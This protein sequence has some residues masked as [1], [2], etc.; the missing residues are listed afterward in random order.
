MICMATTI[1]NGSCT[2]NQKLIINNHKTIEKWHTEEEEEDPHSEAES[3][4]QEST[5]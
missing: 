4:D 1:L 5:M 3:Q 2:I